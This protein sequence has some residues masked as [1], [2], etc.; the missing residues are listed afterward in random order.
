[1]YNKCT[2]GKGLILLLHVHLTL[3]LIMMTDFL[4]IKVIRSELREI[5]KLVTWDS[6]NKR[7]FLVLY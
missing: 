5:N 1:M 3:R 7:Q 2:L 6:R 4:R